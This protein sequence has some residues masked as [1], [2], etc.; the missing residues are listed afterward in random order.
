MKKFKI[1]VCSLF[2]ALGTFILSNKIIEKIEAGNFEGSPIT[3]SEGDIYSNGVSNI[4]FT[5]TIIGS[6]YSVSVIQQYSMTSY[7]GCSYSA[8]STTLSCGSNTFKM[9]PDNS[10]IY[11]N[12]TTS[13]TYTKTQS[14]TQEEYIAHGNSR[15]NEGVEEGKAE[16]QNNPNNY[17]LYT[18]TQYNDYGTDRFNAGLTSG[19]EDGYNNGYDNGYNIGIQDGQENAA[20]QEK[21]RV[22]IIV[23]EELSEISEQMEMMLLVYKLDEDEIPTDDK[24]RNMLTYAVNTLT[25]ERMLYALNTMVNLSN[26]KDIDV[27]VEEYGSYNIGNVQDLVNKLYDGWFSNGQELG[28][29]SGLIE[30]VH[31]GREQGY[32]EGYNE[33]YNKYATDESLAELPTEILS[34]FGSFIWPILTYEVFGISIV[35][36]LTTLLFIGI[37]YLVIKFLV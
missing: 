7:S 17:N 31:R 26:E 33:A 8:S 16:I 21:R 2:L 28:F 32:E 29:D 4:G 22:Y 15:Y 18:Q 14:Y 25:E 37:I 1:I 10:V 6:N 5:K 3:Y 35:S 19:Y 12:G 11:N 20:A 13:V 30:G 27:Q 23:W 34:G 24:I 9:N 36:I